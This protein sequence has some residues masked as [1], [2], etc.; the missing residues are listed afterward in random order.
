MGKTRVF[1]IDTTVHDHQDAVPFCQF[2]R[3]FVENPF[4]QP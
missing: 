2:G 4:L 1:L 3:Y